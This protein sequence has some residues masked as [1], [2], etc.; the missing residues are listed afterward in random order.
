MSDIQRWIDSLTPIQNA[1]YPSP[2]Q[3]GMQAMIE[4]PVYGAIDVAHLLSKIESDHVEALRQAEQTALVKYNDGAWLRGMGKGYEQGQRDALAIEP[5]ESMAL[6]VAWAQLQRG[7]Q[8]MDNV[9]AACVI[10]LQR[11]IKGDSDD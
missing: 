1:S 2:R 8:P 5:A 10:A 9:A 7:E 11:L 3:A 4:G 6:S